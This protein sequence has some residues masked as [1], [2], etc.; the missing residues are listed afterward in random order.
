MMNNF[1]LHI[2]T[3]S[4][5]GIEAAA[6]IGR[7]A[8]RLGT[9]FL[10]VTENQLLKSP[11]LEAVKRS[12]EN[13]GVETIV[14]SDIGPFPSSKAISEAVELAAVSKVD[15]IIGFGDIY[16]LSIAK[17]AAAVGRSSR[18][19]ALI[20]SGEIDDRVSPYPYF[21]IPATVRSP[22]LFSRGL[23]L[24]DAR[25]GEIAHPLLPTFKAHSAVLDP[26]MLGSYSQKYS[27]SVVMD[28]LLSAVEGYFSSESTFFSDTLLLRAIG[29]VL[30][31]LQKLIDN[32]QEEG[33]RTRLQQAGF[34]AAYGLSMST[35][36]IGTATSHILAVQKR[37]PQPVISTILLPY[38]LEYGV[39]ACPD[40]V[41]R[42]GPMLGE[43]LKGL[44]VVAAADRVVESIRNYL[45]IEQLPS[46]LSELGIDR[47]DIQEASAKAASW[48][49]LRSLPSALGEEEIASFLRDA[50]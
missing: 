1:S 49:L 37:V 35:E 15:G 43:N 28:L 2:P 24:I 47:N 13:Q 36:G 3:T 41:S 5:C 27:L 23:Y 31:N 39:K 19:S 48:P 33:I 20:F 10:L 50:L 8:R 25:N 11:A 6:H 7:A 45:G 38:V 42:M 14:Y 22:F 32:S 21:E 44:S 16:T 26:A 29:L 17:A 18:P 12:C 4:Y 9:H 46:R 40:K 34:F 30:S